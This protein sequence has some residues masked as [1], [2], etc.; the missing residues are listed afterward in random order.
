MDSPQF[1]ALISHH[2]PQ[3]SVGSA[4]TII[5]GLGFLI[6]VF[7]IQL[8]TLIWD[9]WQSAAIWLLAPGPLFGLWHLRRL[10]FKRADG[11]S[12]EPCAASVR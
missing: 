4:L 7:S 1:S 8:L 3:D 10:V 5:N 11:P 9:D 6:T 2:A 12:G